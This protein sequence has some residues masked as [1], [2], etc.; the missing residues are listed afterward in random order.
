M[1]K[2]IVGSGVAAGVVVV[3]VLAGYWHFAGLL[4]ERQVFAEGSAPEE[5]AQPEPGPSVAFEVEAP[6]APE[7]AEAAPDEPDAGSPAPDA[8][9]TADAPSFELLRVEPD[10]SAVI[11]G[12]AAPG[13]EV[14]LLSGGEVI[15]S[16][17]ASEAGDFAMALT[18]PL[19][20][21]E[22]E[23]TLQTEDEAGEATESAEAAIVSVP[24]T[25]RE[26]ELLV[27]LGAPNE[28]TRILQRPALAE[29]AAPS[30][31][32][33]AAPDANEA[34]PE[35]P[36]AEAAATAAQE[37]DRTVGSALS[38][39]AVEIERDR[40]YVAGTT[41]PGGRVRVY[42]DDEFLA[43]GQGTGKEFIAEGRAEVSVGSHRVR[44]DEIGPDGSVVARV[45][46]PFDRPE[47]E[48]MAA[49]APGIRGAEPA[50]EREAP[51]VEAEEAVVAQPPADPEPTTEAP[52]TSVAE[53][54]P[55]APST[56]NVASETPDAPEPA[57]AS[58][59]AEAPAV[60]VAPV[61]PDAARPAEAA[62]AASE[63]VPEAPSRG[64]VDE[65]AGPVEGLRTQAALEPVDGRVIIRR[66]DTLWRISRDTYGLGRRYTVIYLANGDQIRDPD[67]I[68]PGQVFRLPEETDGETSELR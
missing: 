10:G 33:A 27:A 65:G 6:P 28:P 37:I 64:A 48:S 11:A 54:A 55:T 32:P 20:V 45:E 16:E 39:A 18:D 66:G 56:A 13:S 24:D 1:K 60:D 63:P 12:R 7:T 40:I 47:G 50:Q 49:L 29:A 51:A 22:H 58:G 67:L 26:E 23:L 61:Q 52:S 14:K 5:T 9:A 19:A 57:A 4:P 2:L 46:V 36:A 17:R 25:G 44:A 43:E 34:G 35:A 31:E 42:V 3:G 53:P 21:G 8:P 15:A 38:I 68:Y 62:V 30:S 41:R 59:N